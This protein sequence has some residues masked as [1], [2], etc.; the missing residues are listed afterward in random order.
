MCCVVH[1]IKD[2][3]TSVFCVFL[4]NK[5]TL[6]DYGCFVMNKLLHNLTTAQTI[7]IKRLV[8][9]RILPEAWIPYLKP[10]K[11]LQQGKSSQ[12]R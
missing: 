3:F 7:A 6:Q 12:A 8:I 1:I 9:N 11:T 5:I 10:Q 2:V 4:K